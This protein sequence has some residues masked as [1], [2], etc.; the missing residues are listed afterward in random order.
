MYTCIK[1]LS[2][3][4]LKITLHFVGLHNVHMYKGIMSNNLEDY[5]TLCGPHNVHMYKGIISNNLEDYF[6][7]I[8]YFLELPKVL[9][10]EPD[11]TLG[12]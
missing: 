3:T 10:S 5:F 6:H 8:M 7:T 4:T 9:I 2:L 1:A 11:L 12:V